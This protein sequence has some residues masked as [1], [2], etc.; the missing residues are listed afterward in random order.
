M[1]RIGWR[2]RTLAAQVEHLEARRVMSVEPLGSG[3]EPPPVEAPSDEPDED[4]INADVDDD[5]DDE[6]EE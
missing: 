1:R 6:N 3:L 5:D 4:E 2:L